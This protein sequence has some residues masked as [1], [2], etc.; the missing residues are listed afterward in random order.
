MAKKKAAKK[1]PAMQKKSAPVPKKVAKKTAS[2]KKPVKQAKPGPKKTKKVAKK[3]GGAGNNNET[4][5]A[6]VRGIITFTPICITERR[7]K[8]GD[9]TTD[10]RIADR[11][12]EQHE[13]D[14]PTH[15]TD[16]LIR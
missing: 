6:K 4:L 3:E 5:S 11:V 1:K 13:N 16:V 7:K 14:F 9:A 12:N 2:K 8:L 15:T 10:R